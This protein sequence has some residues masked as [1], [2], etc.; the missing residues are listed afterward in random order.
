VAPSAIYHHFPSRAAIIQAAVDLVWVEA[1]ANFL[2]LV[3]DPLSDDPVEVLVAVGVATRR[4]FGAHYRIATYAAATPQAGDR[5]RDQMTLMTN[6]F[7]RLGLRG[8]N[9][10][11][12]FHSY[13]SYVFGAA[14]FAAARRIADEQ[15]DVTANAPD[16]GRDDT[17][18]PGGSTKTTRRALE[19][20][21]N[22][23]VTDPVED[24]ALFVRGLRLYLHSLQHAT[25]RRR[26]RRND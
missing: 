10:G 14:I 5:Q 8:D 15:L 19:E 16:V 22:V 18:V 1:A 2:D 25:G 11:A 23:S 26:T 13:A 7:E 4:A 21:L 24:E 12:A 6:V 9:A 3:D 20:A 17:A